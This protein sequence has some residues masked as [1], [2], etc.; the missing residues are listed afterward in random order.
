MLPPDVPLSDK[1]Q[2]C[3]R[4]E[5]AKLLRF[6]K[7]IELLDSEILADTQTLSPKKSMVHQ[8]MVNSLF[9]CYR[10]I[11][12][13]GSPNRNGPAVRFIRLALKE[14]GYPLR[15]EAAIGQTLTRMMRWARQIAAS[16]L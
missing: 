14:V 8:F 15:T 11:V 1:V 16:N 3:R 5:E 4:V 12:G 2:A 10:N 6:A 7:L 13:S 9:L